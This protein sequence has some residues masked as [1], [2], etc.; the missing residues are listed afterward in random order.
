MDGGA[1]KV[2]RVGGTSG[3]YLEFE[4]IETAN[5]A[6]GCRGG[7]VLVGAVEGAEVV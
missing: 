1:G 2:Q 4:G 6:G 5:F 7:L 3:F